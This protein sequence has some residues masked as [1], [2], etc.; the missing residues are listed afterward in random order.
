MHGT[1]VVLRRVLGVL[2]VSLLMVVLQVGIAVAA[3]VDG[4]GD[5]VDDAVDNCPAVS[6]PYQGDL[7]GDGVG[8]R[9]DPD[10]VFASDGFSGTAGPDLI[11]GGDDEDDLISGEAGN[12]A[13]YGEAGDDQL[14]GGPGDDFLDGGPGDDSLEGGPGCDVFAVDPLSPQTDVIADFELDVD[15]FAFPAQDETADQPVVTFGGDVNLVATF[16]LDGVEL[17]IVELEGIDP[18]FALEFGFEFVFDTSP[19]VQVLGPDLPVQTASVTVVTTP[20]PPPPPS[21]PQN[22][23]A[24]VG[25][26][27]TGSPLADTITGTAAGETINGDVAGDLTG[28]GSNDCIDGGDGA[29]IIS[30]DAGIAMSGDAVGGDDTIDGGDGA[31]TIFGDAGDDLKGDA[32]GGDDTIDGGP[33]AD[34]IFGDAGNELKDNSVGGDDTIDGGPGD[35]NMWG[36]A[37][38]VAAGATAGA[39]T[40]VFDTT[41]DFGNDTIHDAGV[42]GTEDTL[43]FTGVADLV[44]LEAVGTVSDDGTD[45]TVDMATGASVTL[46]GIG[47]AAGPAG[48][49]SFVELDASPE[50]AVVAVA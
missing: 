21:C 32:M 16:T 19:C 22:V 17:G 47:V 48:I 45:V 27:F 3:L 23:L 46:N 50:V 42:G 10:A 1:V 30:G 39:D 24:V 9:C 29:D 8:D 2:T 43:L 28:Q 20:P 14:S 36:D 37:Q 44:A 25:S 18:D 13:L 7:D 4:D 41:T 11:F 35:D 38:I 12:D 49:D 33:G 6:N 31:D 5:L 26:P 34:F 40:F 15:R